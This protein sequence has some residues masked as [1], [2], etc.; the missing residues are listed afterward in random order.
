MFE[1]HEK[2]K[3]G[4]VTL[5]CLFCPEQI[6]ASASY[7]KNFDQIKWKKDGCQYATCVYWNTDNCLENYLEGFDGSKGPQPPRCYF[8]GRS[9]Q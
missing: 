5:G 3:K 7:V 6:A 1:Y 8:G 4:P 9:A 2:V